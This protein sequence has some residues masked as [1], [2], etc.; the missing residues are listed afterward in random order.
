MKYQELASKKHKLRITEQYNTYYFETAKRKSCFHAGEILEASFDVDR[1]M[2]V[3]EDAG[4]S[5]DFPVVVVESFKLL[6]EED[7]DVTT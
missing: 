1:W 3:V 6:V 7:E 4:W 2:F 5:Y